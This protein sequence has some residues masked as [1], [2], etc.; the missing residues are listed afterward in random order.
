MLFILFT[1][2]K[3]TYC[4]LLYMYLS[5]MNLRLLDIVITNTTLLMNIMSIN[6]VIFMYLYLMGHWTTRVLGRQLS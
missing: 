3:I 2:D 4:L 1:V 6:R 5:I